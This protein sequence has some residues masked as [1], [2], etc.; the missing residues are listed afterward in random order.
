MGRLRSQVVAVVLE[1]QPRSR[2][3]VAVL[4]TASSQRARDRAADQRFS[5]RAAR[6]SNPNRQIP[7]LVT[8]GWCAY[9]TRQ[10]SLP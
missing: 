4:R 8:V 7:S 5:W 3:L 10:A 1:R 2:N 9:T 6:D